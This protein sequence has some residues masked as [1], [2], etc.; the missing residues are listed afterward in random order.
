MKKSLLFFLIASVVLT[1]GCVKF[2]NLPAY[3]PAFSKNF[4]VTSLN[5]TADT[6]NVG[7]T[8]QLVAMGTMSDSV[9]NQNNIYAYY[10]VTSSAAGAPTFAIGTAAAPI[11]LSKMIGAPNSSG[12]Y[13]WTAN[14]SLAGI[15]AIANSKLTITGNFIYQMSLSSE[16]GGTATATDAGILNKTVFVQ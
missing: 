1:P 4:S 5:H 12:L 16:G 13:T 9:T 10:T 3:T 2:T 6:V 14:I 15:T 11:K 8:V 7:D